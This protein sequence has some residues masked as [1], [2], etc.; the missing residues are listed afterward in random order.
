[1]KIQ[2]RLNLKKAT[3]YAVVLNG[4]QIL[5]MAALAIYV[6]TDELNHVLQDAVGDFLILILS[7]IVI[8]GAAVDIREAVRARKMGVQLTGLDETVSQMTELNHALRAQRH[9]F[10]NHL[11]V[12][13]S[14][15]EMEEF[16]EARQYISQVY[17]DI[18]HL[19]Q[20]LKTACAPVNA[21]LRAK[22]TEAE[23]RQL[24]LE[25]KVQSAWEH[26]PLPAWEM[27]RVLSNLMDN[28][29]D[30]LQG[31]KDGKILVI[32]S[33]DVQC[34]RFSV[35][36]NG[37]MIDREA[38]EKIFEAGFSMKGEGRGMGLP[39]ARETLQNVH[40]DLTLKSNAQ[41]TVF[42]GYVPKVNRMAG[43]IKHDS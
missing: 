33:E 12:V 23:G 39:I 14:L 30:A 18:Q 11:Q 38:A 34:Y 2:P 42:S 6:L 4:F 31:Q 37:P 29:M 24:A 8:W 26:L 20:T 9:D 22:K 7:A 43:G 35:W 1:M 32:L 15:M 19:S 41:E 16:S 5:A 36:N 10:L 27:C 40:G 21:L 25:V 28:A 17:G 13:Y 3:L